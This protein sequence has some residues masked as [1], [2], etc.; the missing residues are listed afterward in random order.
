MKETESTFPPRFEPALPSTMAA[1]GEFW[2]ISTPQSSLSPR[3]RQPISKKRSSRWHWLRYLSDS[4]K[5]IVEQLIAAGHVTNSGR[6]VLII[7][8]S[9]CV[10]AAGN[11]VGVVV[12]AVPPGSGVA[13][14]GVVPVDAITSVAGQATSTLADLEDAIAGLR[15]GST[16][17]ARLVSPSGARRTVS[18]VLGQ[19]GS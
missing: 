3:S 1:A 12:G 15:S 4:V 10:D 8:G 11:P 17:A 13:V 2:S 5:P 7:Q 14:A 19:L 9:A 16:V 18:I 6:A